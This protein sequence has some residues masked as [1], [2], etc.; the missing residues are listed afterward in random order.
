MV[1][2]DFVHDLASTDALPISVD[3][4]DDC[5]VGSVSGCDD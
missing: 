3:I 1:T 2:H 5:G 4:V